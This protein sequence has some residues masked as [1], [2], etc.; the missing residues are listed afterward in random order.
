MR[1]HLFNGVDKDAIFQRILGAPLDLGKLEQHS[2]LLQDLVEKLLVRDPSL[3]LGTEGAHHIMQHEFFQ[4]IDWNTISE[5]DAPFKPHPAAVVTK[6]PTQGGGGKYA[7]ADKRLFYGDYTTNAAPLPTARGGSRSGT[8]MHTARDAVG[9]TNHNNHHNQNNAQHHN[10]LHH[11]KGNT[12]YGVMGKK[13][14]YGHTTEGPPS[15]TVDGSQRSGLG[16]GQ[17]QGGLGPPPSGQR[18]VGGHHTTAGDLLE[19]GGGLMVVDNIDEWTSLNLLHDYPNDDRRQQQPRPPAKVSTV[20]VSGVRERDERG[21]LG[22][23]VL[24]VSGKVKQRIKKLS[25][26]QQQKD[27][28][29]LT[30]RRKSWVSEDRFDNIDLILTSL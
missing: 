30:E 6:P 18:V 26:K 19:G 25:L 11:P 8:G 17:G 14:A 28:I 5:S 13:T 29:Y 10:P 15:A 12:S 4:S 3:R 22:H 1:E 20:G 27:F 21:H 2:V 24:S 7:S 9:A 23:L 16:L